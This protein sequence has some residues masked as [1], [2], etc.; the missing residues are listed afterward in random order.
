MSDRARPL[1]VIRS[2]DLREHKESEPQLLTVPERDA[3]KRSVPKL[4]I[5]PVPERADEYV[6]NPGSTV[7]ALEINVASEEE[8]VGDS[9]LSVLIRP[10]IEISRLLSIACYAQSKIKFQSTDFNFKEDLALPDLLARALAFHARR[11]FSRGLLHGYHTEEDSLH[12]VRGRIMFAEQI[13]RRFGSPLPV[14]VRYDDFTED[15]LANRLVK[16]AVAR[17]GSMALRSNEARRDLRQ[18]STV[19]ANVSW[20]EFP[21][22]AVPKVCFNRLNMHY[23]AVVALSRIVLQHTAFE[24][25]SNSVR[26]SGFLM[27]MN[28]VFQEFVTTALREKL[29]SFA[30]T[31]CSDKELVGR[32]K[33]YFDDAKL[34]GLEPDLTLW[35]GN[36]CTFV[37][38]AKYKPT[39]VKSVP[40]ADL[41]QILAYATALK[42]PGGLLAYAEG[43]AKRIVHTVQYAGKWLE[44]FALDM[45]G[46]LD[47]VLADVGN[48]A[49]RVS[50]LSMR[51]SHSNAAA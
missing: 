11:A 43:K 19:L 29:G 36:K 27:D 7:G 28:V 1:V 45:S 8:D 38:D 41:Y 21:R 12:T 34:V 44:I 23:Q 15:V 24:A 50:D 30:G 35:N 25:Q 10:K 5:A 49:Q 32:R 46:D 3:L 18:I 40:N 16:A 17:I 2:I 47:D 31:L 4:T 9:R 37:G 48:L 39:N 51:A 20:E 13:R 33:I 6:L 14:E 22:N 42:L 26:A